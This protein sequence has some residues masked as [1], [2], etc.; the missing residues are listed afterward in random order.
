MNVPRLA[1]L[2]AILIF[3]G[4]AFL[5]PATIRADSGTLSTGN[6]HIQYTHGPFLVPNLT[7]TVG[8]APTCGPATPCDDYALTINVPA[9]TDSTQQVKIAIS[10]ALPQ[11]DFDLFVLDSTGAVI[12]SAATGAD[13]SVAYIPAVSGTY[14]V[15]VDPY[16]PA[17]ESYTANIDLVTKNSSSSANAAPLYTGTAPR[18]FNYA[19]PHSQGGNA[20]EPSIGYDP[21]TGNVM[22]Q[23]GLQTFR[24]KFNDTTS[25]AQ[26][27]W[28]DV[29]SFSTSKASLDAILFTDQ[30][31]GRTFV[32]QLTGQDSLSAYTDNDGISWT[33]SQGGGIPSGVDHES[34]GGGAYST[35]ATVSPPTTKPVTGYGDA[36]YYCSQ[37]IAAAFCARSDDGGLTYG[38]G[39][40]IYNIN[41]CGGLHGHVKVANDGTVYVPNKNCGG[42]Q[43]VVVSTDD[44]VTWSVRPIPDST[45]AA[46]SDPS[47]AVASDGT[48]YFSYQGADGHAY[49]A[50]SHD[51]GKTWSKSLDV[52]G[53]LGVQN[54]VFPEAVAGD[55]NRASVAYIGTTTG[56]DYQATGTFPG[57]W[58]LY[59][60]TTYDGGKSWV[61]E[62]ATPNDPVQRGSI[63]T[64]GT[65]CGGDRNLLDFN[66][67]TIDSQGRV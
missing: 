15:R 43:A 65:T 2:L 32:S 4:F 14:T 55:G 63:C 38:A 7:D 35:S 21:N 44:G 19:I 62:N 39:V 67:M 61:T 20:G 31:T 59:I 16:T 13:P 37:D 9:G 54:S 36:V 40:P 23:A 45:P 56:G 6:P 30:K 22:Y 42:H 17:G 27:T 24:V 41:D 1:T 66:D 53:Q 51:K 49:V 8:S 29:S 11:T 60:S 5:Q 26:A 18:F 52:G 33:P 57:V 25:P 46:G 50:V 48:L 58:Y 64:N 34:V 12:A 47:V 10:W 28:T 3:G